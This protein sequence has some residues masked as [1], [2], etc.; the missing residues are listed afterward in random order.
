M[1][2]IFKRTNNQYLKLL[3]KLS[4]FK[5]TYLIV[6][7]IG[8]QIFITLLFSYVFFPNHSAGPKFDNQFDHFF[9]PVVIAPLLETFI[10]QYLIQDYILKK[11]NNAYLL[12]CFISSILFG[13]SHYYSPEYILVTFLSGLLF[14]TLYLVS[15]KKNYIPF[16]T[17]AISHSIYN[18]IGFCIDYLFP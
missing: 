2:L 4:E 5:Q 17:V 11:I 16:I 18:F 8:L 6:I 9:L 10:F 12:A 14:S 15:L 1:I 13:L 7:T 3:I